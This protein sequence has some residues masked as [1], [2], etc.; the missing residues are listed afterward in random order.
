[1]VAGSL[2]LSATA[3]AAVTCTTDDFGRP[4][5]DLTGS[6][7]AVALKVVAGTIQLRP[8][9]RTATPSFPAAAG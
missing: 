2:A 5:V 7:D 4:G 6:T 8:G 1:M 3:S 9:G